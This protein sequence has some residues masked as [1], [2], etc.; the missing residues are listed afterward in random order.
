MT[1]EEIIRHYQSLLPCEQFVVTGGYALQR[2]GLTTQSND[3]DII[4]VNPT[5]K[6]KNR[7][8]RLRRNCPDA[9]KDGYDTF[10]TFMHEDIKIDVFL[11]KNKIETLQVDGFEISTVKRIVEA[12]KKMGRTKDWIDLMKLAHSILQK[13]NS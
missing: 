11:E 6:A 3:I 2:F 10:A 12:K 8:E 4:L 7:L 5:D 1:K 9:T 13:L